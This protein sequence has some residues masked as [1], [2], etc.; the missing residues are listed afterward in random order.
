[1]WLGRVHEAADQS[2][3]LIVLFNCGHTGLKHV[4]SAAP[5]NGVVR[6]ATCPLLV[7]RER[8]H[9]FVSVLLR[10]TRILCRLPASQHGIFLMAGLLLEQKC[11][12]CISR[13]KRRSLLVEVVA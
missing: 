1:M 12:G 9:E 8:E 10:V 5:P 6:H 7:V 4:F 2:A 11:H 13:K 3:D